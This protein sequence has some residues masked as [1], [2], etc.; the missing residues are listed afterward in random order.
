MVAIRGSSGE[1]EPARTGVPEAVEP[2]EG[3]CPWSAANTI[4]RDTATIAAPT[5]AIHRRRSKTPIERVI[6]GQPPCRKVVCQ[7][8]PH[9]A[10]GPSPPPWRDPWLCVPASRRVCPEQM[11]PHRQDREE[12]CADS[13]NVRP[14]DCQPGDW[15]E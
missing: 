13:T 1:P 12:T 2:T 8:C 6:S 7:F 9:L 5:P 15:P 11:R 3:I 14:A 4:A 10:A